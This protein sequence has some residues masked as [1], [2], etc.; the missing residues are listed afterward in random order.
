[1]NAPTNV[2]ATRLNSGLAHVQLS[3]SLVSGAAGYEVL[4]NSSTI[5]TITSSVNITSGLIS[6]AT[7][8]FMVISYLD[9]AKSLPNDDSMV[10]ITFSECK[11]L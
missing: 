7:Y 9:D 6:G 8:T 4:F 11:H 3:W 5:N 2:F 1:M 10:K